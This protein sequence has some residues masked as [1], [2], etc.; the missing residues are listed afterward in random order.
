MNLFRPICGLA[1][2]LSAIGCSGDTSRLKDLPKE[3]TFPVTG[4]VKYQGKPVDKASLT[5]QSADGKITARATSDAA[6]V[7]SVSTYGS[8]DGAP[9]GIYKVVVAVNMAKEISPGVLAPEP[10][11]GFKSPIPSRY[12]NPSTSDLSVEV[13]GSGKNDLQIDLK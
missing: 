9:A 7:F 12:S 11:G 6:G 10:P 4:V 5:F 1:L 3:P 8:N 2:S 13:K